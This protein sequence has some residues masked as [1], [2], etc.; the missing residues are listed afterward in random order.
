MILALLAQSSLY[1]FIAA[2][3]VEALVGRWRIED[4]AWR[5][6]LRILALVVSVAAPPV[7]FLL[8]PFRQSASFQVNWALFAGERWDQ[9]RVG[10]TG[11]GSLT[12]LLSCGLGSALFLRDALPPLADALRGSH[13]LPEVPPWHG[14]RAVLAPIVSASARAFAVPAPAVRVVQADAPV[15]LCEGIRHPVLVVSPATLE[16]L[17]GAEL[18][19]AVAHEIA[20]AVHR[21][22]V[23]SYALIVVRAMLFF[24][25]A[26]QWVARAMV[27][28]LEGRADQA[29]VRATGGAAALARVI[30]TLFDTG[31]PPPADGDASFER[32]FWRIRKQ[33]VERRCAR[34][35][36]AGSAAPLLHGPVLLAMA[37]AVLVSLLFFVV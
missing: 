32:V 6:R 24:N 36:R 21:D 12:L 33:G 8:A 5:L 2:L 7:L 9:V 17:R 3:F 34:L 11:L 37:G 30:R 27:D 26:V 28:D 25:P 19:A 35:E 14:A 23:W 10:G 1:A 22:P 16:R 4:A 15:L 20:H 18:E 13:P 29:A 31:H